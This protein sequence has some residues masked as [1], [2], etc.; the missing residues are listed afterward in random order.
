MKSSYKILQVHRLDDVHIDWCLV[1]FFEGDV[2]TENEKDFY[3]GEMKPVIRYRPTKSLGEVRYTPADFGVIA[4]EKELLVF[5]NSELIK[6]KTRDPVA[7]QA[8]LDIT[9]VK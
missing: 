9:K 6:D 8:T 3:T 2:T 1:R 4:T 5:L 7:T